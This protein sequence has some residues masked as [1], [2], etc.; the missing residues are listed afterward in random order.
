MGFC[1]RVYELIYAFNI[2]NLNALT[3]RN[4]KSLFLFVEAMINLC[5][6]ISLK[7]LEISRD[8]WICCHE[9]NVERRAVEGL[10]KSFEGLEELKLLINPGLETDYYLP[11]L[12]HHR[13]TLKRLISHE[14]VKDDIFSHR[15]S[16]IFTET[17]G[18]GITRP[19]HV[20]ISDPFPKWIEETRLDFLGI[21]DGP[22]QLVRVPEISF[23][24]M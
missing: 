20:A 18:S 14:R 19:D 9:D 7:S 13:S 15:D 24:Q 8:D 23:S 10:L 2:G 3:I 22:R 12:L 6:E 5:P 11:S 16:F 1:P 17:G 4:C 21:C